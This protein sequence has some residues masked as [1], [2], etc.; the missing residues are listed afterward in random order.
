MLWRAQHRGIKEMDIILGGFAR[1]RLQDMTTAELDR[2]EHILEVPDQQFLA[3][4]T[5]TETVPAVER[6]P[7][8]N[9]IL[10]FRPDTRP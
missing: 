8:L 9:D 2:F 6:C 3:W 5:G 10:Q 1:A 7:L 4:I